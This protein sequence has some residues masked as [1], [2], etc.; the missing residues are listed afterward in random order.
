MY[1]LETGETVKE[2]GFIEYD[3]QVGVSPDGMIGE[4]GLVEIKCLNDL[5]HFKHI[6]YGE[7]NIDSGHKWQ[8]QMQMLVSGRKWCDY[9]LYNPNYKKSL[10]VYRIHEDKEAHESLLKGF[11]VAKKKMEE[12]KA[13]VNKE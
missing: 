7:A 2:V 13:L 6:L 9:V 8:M 1:E 10:L 3:E 4:D 12:I 11:E 5:N